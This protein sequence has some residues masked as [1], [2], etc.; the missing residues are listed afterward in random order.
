MT[1]LRVKPDG[2][3]DFKENV[4]KHLCYMIVLPEIIEN[5]HFRFSFPQY[6]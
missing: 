3:L 2:F 4:H 6:E 1:E 5:V